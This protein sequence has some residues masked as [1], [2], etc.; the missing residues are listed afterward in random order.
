[1]RRRD[2]LTLAAS[3]GAMFATK[4][5]A[6]ALPPTIPIIDSHVHLFDTARP[7]GV[8]WPEKSDPILYQ[9]A[10]P[11][12]LKSVAAAL[13]VVGA[14]AIEASPLASDNDW[15]LKVASAHPMIVG[16]VGDLV[17]GT[18]SYLS[19]LE[20]LHKNP[21]FLG[22]RYGNLWDRDL[23]VDQQKAGFIAGLKALAAHGLVLESANPNPDLIRALVDVAD[24]LPDLTIVVDHLPHAPVPTERKDRDE[25]QSHLR[26]LARNPH[27]FIKLSEIPV[28]V[29]Q[30]VSLDPEFYR[31]RLDAIW[32]VFGE[33]R[34]LFG[35]D[36]P[37]SDHFATYSDT[38][39]IVRGYVSRKGT[40]VC[41]KFF[42]RNSLAA[43]KW[44][45]R[46]PD[47]PAI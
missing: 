40:A 33:D 27:V 39:G 2:V 29:N 31:D 21:L 30:K 13:G 15:V 14:I 3:A 32:D 22:I 35:S 41:Q 23:A 4:R 16:V 34:I 17:P 38:L 43:Y 36:W 28:R 24:K 26:H 45:R 6:A 37:N 10:L 44:Q 1:M 12:R 9:P 5:I 20:R 11:D 18:S 47:Q 46:S 7:G 19:D 8:P 25:Y 42:W